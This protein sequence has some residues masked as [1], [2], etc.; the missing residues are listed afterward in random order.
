MKDPAAAAGALAEY[1]RDID[2]EVFV[3]ALLTMRNRVLGL[4][5]VAVGCLTGSV[6]LRHYRQLRGLD[7]RAVRR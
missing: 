2:R 1:I 3:V 7:N 4:H 5:T 6:S